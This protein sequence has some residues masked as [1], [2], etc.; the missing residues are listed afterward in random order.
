VCRVEQF[1]VAQAAQGTSLLVRPD[2]PF[3][4]D[5]LVQTLTNGPGHIR[6]SGLSGVVRYQVA[7]Y[8]GSKRG[9]QV[10]DLKGEPQARGIV[11]NDEHRVDGD[12]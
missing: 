12:L 6:A 9:R 11:I 5:D 4:E 3:A 10:I 1:L 2:D 8:D 7:G